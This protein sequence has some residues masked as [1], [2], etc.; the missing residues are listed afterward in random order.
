MSL[1]FRISSSLPPCDI[2][3]WS[4]FSTAGKIVDISSQ[5]REQTKHKRIVMKQGTL[6]AIPQIRQKIKKKC[7]LYMDHIILEKSHFPARELGYL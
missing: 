3:D 5:F 6:Q 4:Q 2:H 1:S 7:S